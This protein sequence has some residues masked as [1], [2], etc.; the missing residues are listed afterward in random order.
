MDNRQQQFAREGW[1]HFPRDEALLTWLAH[2]ELAARAA[3]E[4][5][6]MIAEYLD[7]EGTW[8]VGVDAL[9]NDRSGAV[10]AGPA[11]Q[12]QAWRFV[13]DLYGE[14][15]LHRG[16]VSVVHKGY[17]RPRSY[18]STAN[19]AYRAKRDAAHVDGLRRLDTG[20]VLC[21]PHAYVLGIPVDD[22]HADN[23]PLVLWPGSHVILHRAF[24]ALYALHPIAAW[25]T[26]DVTDAYTT[27]RREVFARCTRTVI[28][29][30]R[31]EAYVLHRH[32]L[33]G[34]APWLGAEEGQRSVI[35]FRPEF[36]SGAEGWVAGR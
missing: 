14:L 25:P 9:A 8:F 17:P 1:L 27:A 23:G 28:T 6:A 31:G 20:R 18:E 34:M 11:L 21:E 29:A 22:C 19:S 2:A 5:P 12:G 15:P 13:S 24:A 10:A 4:D 3:R 32:L 33:H 16:Q 30:R 7:C 35:Y 26:L 36:L